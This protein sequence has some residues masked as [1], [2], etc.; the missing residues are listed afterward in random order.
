M[1][2]LISEIQ[3]ASNKSVLSLL[4]LAKIPREAHIAHC[5]HAELRKGEAETLTTKGGEPGRV[6]HILP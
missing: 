5:T 4:C 3:K 6:S 1:L 2:W